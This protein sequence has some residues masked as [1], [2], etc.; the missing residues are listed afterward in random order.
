MVYAVLIAQ[1]GIPAEAIEL[2]IPLNVIL[3]FVT[4]GGALL[5]QS[6]WSS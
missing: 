1:L 5:R 3:D 2:A 6:R 4:R